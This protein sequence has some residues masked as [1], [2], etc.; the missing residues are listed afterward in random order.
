M[1]HLL[2]V[3]AGALGMGWGYLTAARAAGIRTTLV[4]TPAVGELLADRVD[5]VHH[6]TGTTDEQWAEA[7]YAAAR[8]DRP[9]G[10]VAFSESHVTA[11]ALVQDR[12]GLP[13]PG[14]HAATVSR[15]KALQRACFAGLPQPSWAV[16]DSLA[17]H[18]PTLPA[19]I[20]PLSSTGSHGVEL[21]ADEAA[22][23]AAAAVRSGRLLVESVATGPEY[24]WEGL[25]QDG[26]ILFGNVTAKETTGPPYFIE[27]AHR[28]GHVFGDG[29]DGRVAALAQ[30]VT[31][32]LDMRSGLVHLEF[33]IGPT[34]PVIMEVAVRTPGDFLMDVV[35]RTHGFDLFA[36]VVAL[37]LGRAPDLT[38]TGRRWAASWFP[39]AT[40]GR[41]VGINGL[42][43][44]RAVPGVARAVVH[45]AVGD[46]VAP[47]R[48]SVQR[49][50]YVL[51]DA[52]SPEEREQALRSAREYLDVVT[53]PA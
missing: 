49:A 29:T 6:T 1:P 43:R 51:V 2:L 7:A 41:V 19:V 9:D 26:K 33:K 8:H 14:L 13:G 10:V 53:E 50:G 24:S 36:S 5:A 52:A 37:S 45:H 32:A 31:S 3:G 46:L 42:D 12:W 21:V 18:A 25:V 11:A 15:N 40:P 22:Y 30:D 48:S 47:A 4:E 17:G 28:P 38:S 20:K 34:G 39:I 27:T 23:R 44:V 35:S 16:T